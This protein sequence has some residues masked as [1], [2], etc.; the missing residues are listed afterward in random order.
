MLCEFYL[1]IKLISIDNQKAT[2]AN[3][4]IVLAYNI[5][6]TKKRKRTMNT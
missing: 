6:R 5:S 1:Y 4:L 2:Y 3:Y